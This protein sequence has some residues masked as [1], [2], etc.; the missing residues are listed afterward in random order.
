MTEFHLSLLKFG[1]PL[2]KRRCQ[3]Q[4]QTRLPSSVASPA[5]PSQVQGHTRKLLLSSHRE[6]MLFQA[7]GEAT[8]IGPDK[9]RITGRLMAGTSVSQAVPTQ[10]LVFEKTKA[11]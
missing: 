1:S 6:D 2:K 11:F 8:V 7:D 9:L 3:T 5:G 4:T 10:V